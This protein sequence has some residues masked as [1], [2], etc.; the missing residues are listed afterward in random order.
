MGTHNSYTEVSAEC[1]IPALVCYCAVIVICFR[2]NYGMFRATRDNPVHR[3][4]AGLSLALL[5]GTLVYSIGTFFFHMAY[6]AVLPGLSA[7]TVA[8]YFVTKPVIE[9][10]AKAKPAAEPPARGIAAFR[11]RL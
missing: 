9:A 4:V 5:S 2:L 11:L 1:G 7:M 8:L 6:S 10:S 3:E